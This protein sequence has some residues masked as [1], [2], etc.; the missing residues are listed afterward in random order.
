MGQPV[1]L[2]I[3]FHYQRTGLCPNIGGVDGFT[4]GSVMFVLTEET[5]GILVVGALGFI[6]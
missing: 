3:S 5:A 4:E 1:E 6:I 2:L